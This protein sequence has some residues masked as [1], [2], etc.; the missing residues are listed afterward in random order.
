MNDE[1]RPLGKRGPETK[2]NRWRCNGATPSDSV[3]LTPRT[4]CLETFRMFSRRRLVEMLA[5]A[6]GRLVCGRASV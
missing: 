1:Q 6:F 4:Q 3:L 5:L 2:K